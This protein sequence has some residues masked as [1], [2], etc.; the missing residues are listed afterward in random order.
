MA[1]LKKTVYQ[2]SL[3][4][5]FCHLV[6]LTC[7]R[8]SDGERDGAEAEDEADSLGGAD[9]A[10]DL[11]GDGAEHGDEAAVEEAEDERERRHPPEGVGAE[12]GR[13]RQQHRADADGHE[14]DLMMHW[15]NG[16]IIIC[17]LEESTSTQ[18]V[19]HLG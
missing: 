15:F 11:E 12:E 5:L 4:S 6:S 18:K 13:R 8:R 10:A 3:H 7:D 19:W 1:I 9:R 2:T 14:G 17:Y 16:T